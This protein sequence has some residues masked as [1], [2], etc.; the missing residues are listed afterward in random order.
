V[1]PLEAPIHPGKQFCDGLNVSKVAL[2]FLKIKTEILDLDH[3]IMRRRRQMTPNLNISLTELTTPIGKQ[4]TR[5]LMV[6]IAYPVRSNADVIRIRIE[7][8]IKTMDEID[9]QVFG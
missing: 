3:D 8:R 7:Q 1:Y 5:Q 6:D 4:L 9:C 2:A